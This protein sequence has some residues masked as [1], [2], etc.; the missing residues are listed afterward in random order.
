MSSYKFGLTSTTLVIHYDERETTPRIL[1][2]DAY[3]LTEAAEVQLGIRNPDSGSPAVQNPGYTNFRNL[4][5]D[6]FVAGYTYGGTYD[7]FIAITTETTEQLNQVKSQLGVKYQSFTNPNSQAAAQLANETKEIL[8]KYNASVSI[9]IKTSGSSA[10]PTPTLPKGKNNVD[11]V[12][13]VLAELVRFKSEL[14][15]QT[16]AQFAPFTVYLKRYS[17]L[18][19]VLEK[20]NAEGNDGTVP[21]AP[22]TATMIQ[23]INRALISLGGHHQVIAGLDNSKIDSAVRDDYDAKYKRIIDK[24][25]TNPRFY[26]DA[27]EVKTTLD[28]IKNLSKE[29]KAIGDRYVFYKMLIASQ[30]HE[31]AMYNQY[32][33]YEDDADDDDTA[34]QP[35]GGYKGGS[36]G[37]R[38]FFVSTAVTNDINAGKSETLDG[39]QS[40][41]AAGRRYWGTSDHNMANVAASYTAKTSA[42]GNDA[43][44]CYVSVEAENKSD[45]HRRFQNYPVVGK[46]SLD[47]DFKSGYSRDATWLVRYQTMQ[48]TK[49][50]YPFFGL[51]R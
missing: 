23:D 5:G 4:Y 36:S 46:S 3:Q 45:C 9:E 31:R 38:E 47:F 22:A 39:R 25:E 29:L 16:P 20:M 19:P 1:N 8:N 15:Q 28:E 18:K 43:L 32:K 49:E 14:S 12:G 24:I 42:G 44:F 40:Y 33:A 26:N 51:D 17:L 10:N 35:F 27:N 30:N 48:F 6:Y 2:D 41:K 50:K 13:D 21:I 37:Y 7:A 34:R 11:S